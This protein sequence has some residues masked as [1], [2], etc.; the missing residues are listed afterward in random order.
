MRNFDPNVLVLTQGSYGVS[1]GRIEFGKQ[2]SE[3]EREALV[4]APPRPLGS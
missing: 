1:G 2:P 3:F 4:E